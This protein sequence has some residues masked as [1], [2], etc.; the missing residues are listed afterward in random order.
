MG[1]PFPI[2]SSFS[3]FVS[4]SVDHV[5][6]RT[7][8]FSVLQKKTVGNTKFR[9]TF[10]LP[11]FKLRDVFFFCNTNFFSPEF[12]FGCFQAARLLTLVK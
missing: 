9:V 12:C 3:S 11:F 8:T 5:R 4:D 10:F 7:P 1:E 6:S 2:C